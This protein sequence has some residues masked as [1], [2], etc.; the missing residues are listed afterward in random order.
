MTGPWDAGLQ[1]ERTELAWRRTVLAVTAGTVV[2]ARY[3]GASSVVLGLALPLLALLGGLLL[4]HAGTV[5]FRRLDA[6]LRE[7]G[8]RPAGPVMPGAGMLATLAA[9]CV[10][11]GVVSAVFVVATA[12]S[13]GV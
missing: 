3:L 11:V 8:P 4:L 6:A 2:A 12:V 10:G 7:A 13:R 9:M 5:R 1:P